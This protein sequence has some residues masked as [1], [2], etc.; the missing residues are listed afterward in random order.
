MAKKTKVT[1]DKEQFKKDV[2]DN[3]KILFRIPL[4]DADSKQIFKAAAY[5]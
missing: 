5:G 2:E 4:K 3:V 1:F